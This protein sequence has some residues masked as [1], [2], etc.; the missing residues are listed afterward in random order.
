MLKPSLM[1]SSWRSSGPSEPRGIRA[2]AEG[3]HGCSTPPKQLLICAM[4]WD[5]NKQF[6]FFLSILLFLSL[7][8]PNADPH[9]TCE[10][11]KAQ[12]RDKT[13]LMSHSTMVASNHLARSAHFML[14][15]TFK[16]AVCHVL[17]GPGQGESEKPQPLRSEKQIPL[18]SEAPPSQ[19]KCFP[20]NEHMEVTQVGG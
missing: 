14:L 11:T 20:H 16:S 19:N 9:S 13:D 6:C 3:G 15:A 8:V 5:A 1:F 4:C 2:W 7:K 10:K 18:R 17:P 12:N